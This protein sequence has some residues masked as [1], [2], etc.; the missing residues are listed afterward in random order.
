MGHTDDLMFAVHF[1]Y[2]NY[3][4]IKLFGFG[5]RRYL[6]TKRASMQMIKAKVFRK[7]NSAFGALTLVI[8]LSLSPLSTDIAQA[9]S[10]EERFQDLFVTAGY[11]T[12]FGAAIGTAF[13]A[14]HEDP[15]SHL[16]YVAMGASL[17][18]LGGSILGSYVIFSPMI[19]ENGGDASAHS[20]I[21]SNSVPNSG[22]ALRP[23]WN[24]DINRFASIEAG[25][26]FF[27]F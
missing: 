23:T 7:L 15:S 18:F 12:A 24:K 21:A 14:F 6:T 2:N 5:K 9:Q 3:N 25:M 16:R 17:G 27:N 26:T 13:L 1:L 22:I 19:T 11:A 4:R 8:S 20:L 10:V